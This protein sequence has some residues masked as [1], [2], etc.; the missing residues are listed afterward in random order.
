[1]LSNVFNFNVH[2]L[3]DSR[4]EISMFTREQMQGLNQYGLCQSNSSRDQISLD[5][6]NRN[7]FLVEYSI[8]IMGINSIIISIINNKRMIIYSKKFEYHRFQK[9]KNFN[10]ILTTMENNTLSFFS[11][12]TITYIQQVF[13]SYIS[14][15]KLYKERE[16]ARILIFTLVT[17]SMRVIV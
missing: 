3:D 5:A 10:K 14:F 13:H 17:H 12:Y 16:C 15:S 6:N 7:Y 4:M 1:M 9:K 8:Q 11:I 2:R